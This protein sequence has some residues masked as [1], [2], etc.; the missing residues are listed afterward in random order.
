MRST[1]RSWSGPGSRPWSR[2]SCGSTPLSRRSRRVWWD[3]S[4]RKW[5]AIVAHEAKWRP[6]GAAGVC[7]PGARGNRLVTEMDWFWLD[8][9]AADLACDRR[10]AVPR[11]SVSWRRIATTASGSCTTWRQVNLST[12]QPAATRAASRRRSS[13]NARRSPCVSHPSASTANRS[14]G[15]LKSTSQ[16]SPE[17]AIQALTSGRDIPR[18][19]RAP[20]PGARARPRPFPLDP[21]GTQRPPQGGTPGVRGL[22]A[23]SSAIAERSSRPR[24]SAL[25]SAPGSVAGAVAARPS[26]VSG[27]LAHGIASTTSRSVWA[28]LPNTRH[29]T[30]RLGLSLR[31]E[32][33][34][35]APD[36]SISFRRW[37]AERCERTT[38]SPPASVAASQRP[39]RRRRDGRRRRRLGA[40]GAIARSAHGARP[41]AARTRSPPAVPARPPRAGAPRGRRALVL[42]ERRLC[43]HMRPKGAVRRPCRQRRAGRRTGGARIVPDQSSDASTARAASSPEPTAPS[44]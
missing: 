15:Q 41:H 10:P 37:A 43:H 7:G 22:R 5:G 19:R 34:S 32:V 42:D 18:H 33:I 44:M 40:A 6:P 36:R 17:T 23:S 11:A 38:P 13:S 8:H 26:S 24:R 27:T 16:P 9:R 14:E 28:R 2:S 1:S 25:A 31:L 4:S 39:R 29:T 12:R 30:P 3:H 20:A 35:V 21:V